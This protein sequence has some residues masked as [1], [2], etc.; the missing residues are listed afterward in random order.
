MPPR[1]TT[2]L[3]PPRLAAP[4]V[5]VLGSDDDDDGLAPQHAP[6]S[7]N[8]V[9][10]RQLELRCV[11][12]WTK[13]TQLEPQPATIAQAG[14]EWHSI[15]EIPDS[16]Q[17]AS[18]G[19]DTTEPGW[20]SDRADDHMSLDHTASEAILHRLPDKAFL[21]SDLSSDDSTDGL[22]ARR[23][24]VTH[25]APGLDDIVKSGSPTPADTI[26]AYTND[27]TYQ[28]I[29]SYPLRE[30][31]FQQRMPYT[32]DKQQHARWIGS[33]NSL[34]R[35]SQARGIPQDDPLAVVYHQDDAEDSDYEEPELRLPRDPLTG[36]SAE[37]SYSELAKNRRDTAGLD[38]SLQ[39]W[40]DDDLPTVQDLRRQYQLQRPE[41]H[42]DSQEPLRSVPRFKLPSAI[43]VRAKRKLE[44]LA[45]QQPE[46]LDPV[47]VEP[48]SS[49]Q[50]RSPSIDLGLLS[51]DDVNRPRTARRHHHEASP[52][53]DL[54]IDME[55]DAV[56]SGRGLSAEGD[57]GQE[58]RHD[59][60]DQ[61]NTQ[62]R[63][64]ASKIKQRRQHVLPMSFFKRNMLPD[65]SAA[66]RSLR[67]MQQQSRRVRQGIT[68]EVATSEA[69]QVQH[70]HHAKR[71]IA[72]S[73]QGHAALD[74][75]I[76]QLALDKSDSDDDLRHDSQSDH[77]HQGP[78]NV[79]SGEDVNSRSTFKDFD[80]FDKRP[81][82][83]RS[84]MKSSQRTSALDV[85]STDSDADP[86]ESP[87]GH[88]EL[89]S[90]R[91]RKPKERR[92]MP[93]REERLDMIDRMIVR[94]SSRPSNPNQPSATSSS[95]KRRRRSGNLPSTKIRRFGQGSPS[96]VSRP[97][98]RRYP[99]DHSRDARHSP[100]GS[101]SDASDD[102][103]ES[104]Q[105]F[106]S[107][108]YAGAMTHG[109][110]WSS[111]NKFDDY[112]LDM[113]YEYIDDEPSS[114]LQ[115]R[116]NRSEEFTTQ[117]P[118]L[119]YDTA[120][121]KRRPQH[122]PRRL[123]HST[124][125]RKTRPPRIARPSSTQRRPPTAQSAQRRQKT[126]A[127]GTLYPHVI[128]LTQNRPQ[129]VN[130][131]FF[132]PAPK[133][134]QRR[135]LQQEHDSAAAEIQGDPQ[136]VADHSDGN[137]S[138]GDYR[139]Q[140]QP[141]DN[142]DD[143]NFNGA[144]TA[145]I[146]PAP[147]P[148]S[149]SHLFQN[150][151][152]RIRDVPPSGDTRH[153]S[154][155]D[156]TLP[157]GL[158]FSRDGYI[159][160]GMLSQLLQT[161]SN[162]SHIGI[163]TVGIATTTVFFERPFTPQWEDLSSV[164]VELASV[165]L[166]FRQRFQSMQASLQTY[167]VGN[168]YGG[169]HAS[170]EL[171]A[172]LQA[173]ENLTQLL[174]YRF[175][176]SGPS[177][178]A[179]LWEIFTDA[180]VSPLMTLVE[181]SSIGHRQSPAWTL[182]LWTRWALVSWTILAECTR[183]DTQGSIL[184][185]LQPLLVQLLESSDAR[186]W[187]QLAKILEA[188]QATSGAIHG[189][190]LLEVWVCLIQTLNQYSEIFS[191]PHDFWMLFNR[192]VQQMWL[193]DDTT[194][195]EADTAA[196]TAAWEEQANHVMRL[197][198]EV[199]RLHQFERDG[200]SNALIQTRENWALVLWLL[201]K[202]WLERATP[203]EVDLE[204]RLRRLLFF[205]H[206]RI[207]VWGWS[208][209][210]DIVVQIYRF[211]A[212]R[213]FRDLP[214][215]HGYRLPEFLRRM[216]TTTTKG[217]A[218]QGAPHVDG[219]SILE[220]FEPNMEY[221][222]KV[223][224]HDRCFEIYLKIVAKTIH[225]QVCG[226]YADGEA[227]ETLPMLPTLPTPKTISQLDLAD[228]SQLA[229]G[230]LYQ[231]MSRVD[232]IKTCK[233]LLSSISPAMVTTISSSGSSGRTYS[234]LCNPCNLVLTVALLVPEF[235][236]PSTV[237][238][239][240]SLLNFEDSDDASRRILLESIFFLGKI[241]QRQ[242]G[243]ASMTGTS[244]RSLDKIVD[245]FFGRLDFMSQ[246][247]EDDLA[248]LDAS[249]SY[250]PRSKR[251]APVAGL[252]ETT[253]GYVARLLSDEGSMH[254]DQR[255]YPSLL[256]LDE[257]LSRFFSP[258]VA[259]SPELRLQALGIIELF[260]ALRSMHEV[261]FRQSREKAQA[262][263]RAT[264]QEPT[265][266]QSHDAPLAAATDLEA[267]QSKVDTVVDDEFSSLDYEQFEFD[268]K[269]LLD[270]SQSSD[271]NGQD[272]PS[273]NTAPLLPD[274]PLVLA[275]DNQLA[276]VILSWIYPSLERFI[277]ARHQALHE[278]QQKQA[279][280]TIAF[281]QQAALTN[282]FA[283]PSASSRRDPALPD[284]TTSF[285]PS[286]M[287]SMS[288]QGTWRLVSIYAESGMILL[289]QN[290]VTI[291]EIRGL[292]KRESWLSPWIQYWR[293]QDELVW[294]MR[295]AECS[296]RTVLAHEDVFLGVWFSTVGVSLHELTVQHR[297]LK[298]FLTISEYARAASLSPQESVPTLC[299]QLFRDLPLAHLDYS[300]QSAGNMGRSI[301]GMSID[302]SLVDAHQD[303]RLLQEFKEARLQLLTKVLSNIGEHYL[304]VRPDANT[305]DP[306]AFYRAHA[307]KSRFQSYLGLLL[308]Q[309]KRDYERL[310]SKRMVR[311][312]IKHVELAHHVVGQV[313][314]HCGLVLQNSQLAGPHD[315]ILN[316]LT[317]SRLFPQPRADG[318]YVHQKIRGYAYLYQA[319]EKQFFQ[320]LVEMVLSHAK[321]IP[322]KSTMR[323][324]LHAYKEEHAAITPPATGI[325]GLSGENSD[326]NARLGLRISDGGTTVYESESVHH[327]KHLLTAVSAAG[328]QPQINS[329]GIRV[330]LTA[331]A[332]QVSAGATTQVIGIQ[333]GQ[334]ITSRNTTFSGHPTSALG[335]SG[336]NGGLA[337]GSSK[338]T[339][340]TLFASQNTKIQSTQDRSDEALRTLTSS[341]RNV[342]LEA[343]DKKQWNGV[344]SSFRVMTFISIFRPLLTA[345]LGSE[346][347]Q[348]PRYCS[349]TTSTGIAAAHSSTRRL[350]QRPSLMVVAVPAVQWLVSLITALSSDM[351][352]VHS[353]AQGPGRDSD[354][355]LQALEGFQKETSMLFSPL[356]Q[357]LAG[358]FDL[359]NTSWL[360]LARWRLGDL[361]DRQEEADRFLEDGRDG[362][363]AMHLFGQV[364]LVV[365]AL[366]KVARKMQT[367]HSAFYEQNISWREALLELA[368][369]ALDQGFYLMMSLGGPLGDEQDD[370]NDDND[371]DGG[372]AGGSYLDSPAVPGGTAKDRNRYIVA[373]LTS[374]DRIPGA[375]D[376]A[377][378]EASF[379]DF[380]SGHT[381][382]TSFERVVLSAL[383][384]LP[385]LE[386][387]SGDVLYSTSI[388]PPMGVSNEH[389]PRLKRSQRALW[390]FQ[391][392]FLGY[393]GTLSALDARFHRQVQRAFG[394]LL[395]PPSVMTT[396]KEAPAL[397]IER[398][399]M[400]SAWYEWGNAGHALAGSVSD[401]TL[402][403]KQNQDQNGN[404]DE[405]TQSSSSLDALAGIDSL[406]V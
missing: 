193:K 30:R 384:Q 139:M 181:E 277:K 250:V 75:F 81:L 113:E 120:A 355:V 121:P 289:S 8:S 231:A 145:D 4:K 227:V 390:G 248:A 62:A 128:H 217:P 327:P 252:I 82:M 123:C 382:F 335:A 209:N 131:P 161:M 55:E 215:E 23:P 295:V 138:M 388:D 313:I 135:L 198:I 130:K 152:S 137:V 358:C 40:D 94:T 165:V 316:F 343:E 264:M 269:D 275:Q 18:S 375:K 166:D 144:P 216:V 21:D 191:S 208:P 31:T 119:R 314:Q 76:A 360:S 41:E 301:D 182:T 58:S 176:E 282:F 27:K 11:E 267:L 403:H 140:D 83:Q 254:Q 257:R 274:A 169:F 306:K 99:N 397:R 336:T 268:D 26:A 321:V 56:Q 20:D 36:S 188:H 374:D 6:T 115:H 225:W 203:A 400:D 364:L 349:A 359:A 93:F 48:L 310:E 347:P 290:R 362:V 146:V 357:S 333:A 25:A 92:T 91:P 293:L 103:Q 329:T 242:G 298:A 5:L 365:E 16:E 237:G 356:L 258:S 340:D 187:T 405:A 322:A 243:R 311:E 376:A 19:S 229:Q 10:D 179:S 272:R 175:S 377:L 77:S 263:E 167:S 230:P 213:R 151:S 307:V 260:F 210:A 195:E 63:T 299:Q 326:T 42:A 394:A 396:T 177:A 330:D 12:P 192:Q 170:S 265:H 90:S 104:Y 46:T 79:S 204:R 45:R 111:G 251:Q 189:Q 201:Q 129:L 380:L 49:Y 124:V 106:A 332:S 122:R 172:C 110:D 270:F 249:N 132:Q 281:Q 68:D 363:R 117:Y 247:L 28:P 127:Q 379:Q 147:L 200:S 141:W 309:I 334:I 3:H 317:S 406:F 148:I 74:D 367:E 303:G 67:S 287:T 88:D 372:R 142:D 149:K 221:V 196:T 80:A 296:P 278:E 318:V 155:S 112:S 302:R 223:D 353:D 319:G 194:V 392:A 285:K 259:Y 399:D 308:N 346:G 366:V 156:R 168:A 174:M 171:G 29:R 150:N 350:P 51:E 184:T 22:P 315:S 206:S 211:F 164:Q 70:A 232:K 134:A 205:C 331:G 300:S 219:P 173:L 297:F 207:H 401:W 180:V 226:I 15:Q 1:G 266:G 52:G 345:F 404:Q 391:S 71:R 35:H 101:N 9:P 50:A 228:M 385:A 78:S 320:D 190:D 291:D 183:L 2:E 37:R 370:N 86:Y 47:D 241:W 233:R 312:S 14:P 118:L 54:T 84:R 13:F 143:H 109:R 292:F 95:K 212:A 324:S 60:S 125:V 97:N 186:Y 39:D 288:V 199:G 116:D 96:R 222:D 389:T 351:E 224:K 85:V 276:K 338:S 163:T 136:D 344:M 178:C 66:L 72:T 214:T 43:S 53:F 245:Y 273:A 368:Q 328:Q 33:R 395:R 294:A 57:S 133:G 271:T 253:L 218:Q 108:R 284:E 339:I 283:T 61:G 24:T 154:L 244:G 160:R 393:C 7:T 387:W 348:G 202:K 73:R 337:V 354:L 256:Y 402:L 236:R 44:R 386:S 304:V 197:L 185:I 262:Q 378:M 383:H 255:P 69:D 373:H 159:G 305:T 341:L 105:D 59:S 89:S 126:L 381:Q 246:L 100:R 32:A 280:S 162:R 369:F 361:S 157:N 87:V 286:N 17:E 239:L 352:A 38:F 235:I 398:R 240:R 107:Q 153:F 342:A 158:Y 325:D 279:R 114:P 371:L 98:Y 102:F 323:L 65:D 238:Q 64:S 220:E 234:S 261:W 34:S